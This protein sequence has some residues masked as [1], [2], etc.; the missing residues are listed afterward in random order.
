MALADEPDV[1]PVEEPADRTLELTIGPLMAAID[2]KAA[3]YLNAGLTQFS[4]KYAEIIGRIRQSPGGGPVLVYSQ[5]KTLEGLGLFAA[6]LRASDEKYLPLDIVKNPATQQWEIPAA[7]MD[8]ARPRY[9]LYTGDQDLDKRRLLL[10]LYNADV[11][12]LPPKLSEQCATLL[13]GAPDNRDGRICKVFMITQSGAEG[14]SLFNTRQVHIMEPYWN[15]VRLEQVQGRAI[16]LCSHMNLPWEERT[17]DVFTYLSVFS[18]EQ[19]TGKTGYSVL[20][21]DE[22][23]TTDEQIYYI[24]GIKQQLADGLFQIAQA[25]ATD[26]QIHFLEQGESAGVV[27]FE[28]ADGSR[29]GFTYHPDYKRELAAFSASAATGGR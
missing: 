12:G 5:F 27:C 20:S 9:I 19:K 24:A 28:Y 10:Q 29:P 21:A 11:A 3:E 14:I 8:P 1:V 15:N 4:P 17:V 13:A 23:K 18:A 26:C 7:L 2:A 16:R 22:G 6:A 25:A